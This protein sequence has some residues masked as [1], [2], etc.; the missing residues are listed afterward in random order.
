MKFARV[1]I[2][3]RFIVYTNNEQVRAGNYNVVIADS[4]P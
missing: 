4:Y 1:D 3:V 2:A